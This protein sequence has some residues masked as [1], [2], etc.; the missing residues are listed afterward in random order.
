MTSSAAPSALIGHLNGE[1][2]SR[3]GDQGKYGRGDADDD[4]DDE[5]VEEEE[6][7]IPSFH[8]APRRTTVVLLLSPH[9]GI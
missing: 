2:G 9:R 3:T 1:I 4:D 5:V 8:S 7:C 6:E